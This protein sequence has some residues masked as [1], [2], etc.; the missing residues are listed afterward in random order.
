MQRPWTESVLVDPD[1]ITEDDVLT[2]WEREF[3]TAIEEW[4]GELTERP[5]AKLDEI[6]ADIPVRLELAR[7]GLWPIDR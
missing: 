1:D 3:L 6:E 7:Q 2:D 5:Q 4:E